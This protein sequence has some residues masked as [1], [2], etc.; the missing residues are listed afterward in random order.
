VTTFSDLLNWTSATSCPR[1]AGP[2]GPPYRVPRDD[3]EDSFL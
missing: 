3:I 2:N 1:L